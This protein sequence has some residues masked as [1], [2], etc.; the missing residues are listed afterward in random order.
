MANT[1]KLYT[2]YAKLLN[3][4][5]PLQE[6]P[7]PQMVR[8][9]YLN[10]NG[11][12]DYHISDSN[13]LPIHYD[14][15]I[16]VPF[17][18]ESLLSKVY[19]HIKPN[20]YLFYRLV[21]VLP[22]KFLKDLLLLHFDAVD[23]KAVIFINK[24]RVF[25]HVGG[26]FP[27]TV[28]ITPFLQEEN[29]I[30]VQVT[31][32]SNHSF[33]AYGKQHTKPGGIWYT[34]ITGIWQSVWLESVASNH[35]QDIIINPSFDDGLVFFQLVGINDVNGVIKILSNKKVIVEKKIKEPI[36]HILL[37]D[38]IAWT[39]ENP[40]LYQVV[41]ELKTDTIESYFGMR[42]ISIGDGQFG[43][44]LFLNNEEIFLS[45]VLDQGYYSDGLY[46][47]ASDQAFIDDI[48]TMKKMGYNVL[49]KH[50]KIE[51]RRWYY[52]CDRLGMLVWQDMVS[53][54]RYSLPKMSLLPL[55]GI[56]TCDDQNKLKVFGRDQLEAQESFYEEMT[57]TVA[58][59]NS[60]P[61]VIIWTIFN[62]GWGQ[63]NSQKNYDFLKAFDKTRLIDAVS[64]WFDQGGPDFSSKHI[65]F[66]KVAF[67]KDTRPLVLSEFGG[68]THKIPHHSYH[69]TK[70]FG[71]RK[72]TS[73]ESL[74]QGIE[75]L[76][77]EEIIPK[78]KEG[79]CAA[80][81]TQLS[82][83]EEETNGLLTYDREFIKVDSNVLKNIHQ[84]I[85]SQ[86]AK[87]H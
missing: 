64:G 1:N 17:P 86:I 66:K 61:S 7:R 67:D 68:Y 52:H 23:Q 75:K 36:F 31:D 2:K 20:E 44:A 39:P 42:K 21:F 57:N 13:A 51:P 3:E 26:Y 11:Y 81:Y 28:D 5:A 73:N 71:Y 19:K 59:L 33:R 77:K 84:T 79:L 72:F 38:F 56:K 4:D 40:H 43:R 45:G 35:I 15:K 58:L 32:P 9:S 25:E 85:Y 70:E 54:G 18:I 87:K 16:L 10:L 14:G 53:G 49:R 60:N 65:Y 37:S 48:I 50:V 55:L 22:K 27:F 24:Q 34:P 41:I 6:Y 12:W 30:V 46:T 78:I 63:F 69:L 76:Y 82:D 74:Q 47:P 29:E 83:V 8:N 80:I 62:E